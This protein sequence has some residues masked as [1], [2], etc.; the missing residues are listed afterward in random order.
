MKLALIDVFTFFLS[1]SL[2]KSCLLVVHLRSMEDV[3]SVVAW[4]GHRRRHQDISSPVCTRCARLECL[5]LLFLHL[6]LM[7]VCW[8]AMMA[9]CTAFSTRVGFPSTR[10]WL[11]VWTL[12]PPCTVECPQLSLKYLGSNYLRAP[13]LLVVAPSK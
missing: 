11:V 12:T 9:V 1:P 13:S 4:V 7:I 6:H 10:V 5:S 3:T 8:F 2:V